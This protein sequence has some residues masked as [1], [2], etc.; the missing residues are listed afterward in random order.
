M[1]VLKHSAV[2]ILLDI[3]VDYSC[4]AHLC[5]LE[6]AVE[7]R[8]RYVG[9]EH[10]ICVDVKARYIIEYRVAEAATFRDVDQPRKLPTTTYI[11]A[12]NLLGTNFKVNH[13]QRLSRCQ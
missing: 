8:A 11:A 2:A 6:G 12:F 4:K 9:H 7:L 10:S 1:A 3:L 5:L 13:H